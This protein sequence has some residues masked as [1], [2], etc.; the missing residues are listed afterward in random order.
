[1]ADSSHGLPREA[2]AQPLELALRR[3]FCF[4]IFKARD[5]HN[6]KNMSHSFKA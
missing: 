3:P 1:M 2:L 4:S 6:K 5:V